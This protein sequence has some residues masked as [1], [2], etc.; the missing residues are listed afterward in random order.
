MTMNR[1]S[2]R[3]A[4][5]LSAIALVAIA[6]CAASQKTTTT[7]PPPGPSSPRGREVLEKLAASYAT[8]P[9]LAI[10]G[11]M[12]ASGQPVTVWIDAIVRRRDS[13]KLVMTGPFG[14]PVGAMSATPDRFIFFNAQEGEAVEGVPDRPTFE[15]LLTVGL[16]YAEMASLLRGELPAIPSLDSLTVVEDGDLLVYRVRNGSMREEFTIDSKELAVRSYSR[17]VVHPDTTVEEL[18]I[19]YDNFTRLGARTFPR[20]GVVDVRGGIQRISIAIEK[21]ATEIPSGET[22]AIDIPAGVPRKKL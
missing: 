19:R 2:S 15:K 4:L 1:F 17:S 18:A 11:T 6:G 12:R 16:D 22:F 8:T 7:A 5:L 21:L 14:I 9:D 20:K 10:E 13:L 3:S